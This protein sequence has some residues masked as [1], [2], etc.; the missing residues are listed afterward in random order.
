MT[1]LDDSIRRL[2]RENAELQRRLADHD[3]EVAELQRRLA[4]HKSELAEAVAQQAA[5]SELLQVI[6]SSPGDLKPVFDAML[7]KAL[8]LCDAAF[9]TLFVREDSKVRGVATR[10]LPAAL[11]EYV[12]EP[13][14]PS[15]TGFF[16]K[17]AKGQEIDHV[18]DLSAASAMTSSDP[19]ARALVEFGGAR[20]LLAVALRNN[21]TVVGAF[22]IFRTEVRPFT[23]KEI[24]LAQ[25]F[26]AQA[27]IAMENAR[28]ITETR[29]ALEQQTATAEVLQVINSSPGNLAPVFDAI[30]DKAIDVCEAAFGTLWTYDGE[31]FD[32]VALGRVPP[33]FAAYLSQKP[34]PTEPGSTHERLTRGET[35]VQVEDVAAETVIGPARR[36]LVEGGGARTIINVPLRMDDRLLG[37][38]TA[39]R[40]EVRPFT[41]KQIALL[42]NF[43]AQAVIAMENARLITETREALEQQTA[44]AEVLGVINSS[45]GNLAP[46][47]EATLDKALDLCGAAFG[48]LWIC[49]GDLFRAAALRRVPVRYAEFLARQPI[50]PAAGSSVLGQISAGNA[51]AHVLDAASDAAYQNNSEAARSLIELG[52]FRTVAGVPLR[53]DGKLLGAITIYRREVRAFTDKQIALLQNFAAQAV[54]AMENARLLGQLRQRTEE[55]AELNRGLEARVSEQVEELGRVGRLKRFLAPQLAELIVSQG[56]EKILE[57][58]R[59][60]IVVVFCDLRGY[61]AFTETAEPEEVLDFLRQYHGA[62]GPL[63]SRFEGTLDQFS[64]DG[65]MVFF[66][67]PVPV[68]DPAERAVKMAMAMRETA[69]RLITTWRQ[70]DRELGFGAG[71]AQGYATLGQIGF[72]DRSGYTA[73][74]TVCNLAARLCG[75]AKDGQILVAGRV[76]AAVRETTALEDIGPVVLKGLT[77]PVSVFN[78]LENRRT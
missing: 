61:T 11:E 47:F 27:V 24:A 63:V 59:G 48:T 18:F 5:S 37:S 28:L 51:F 69:N 68:P 73:I 56:D 60:E 8:R 67:D 54:I 19:R 58:H 42:Q 13:F 22:S 12:R 2:K 4:E 23:D 30:L 20:T 35:F 33:A 36:A 74:G 38:I 21:D 7:E 43:A 14:D 49:E 9:G 65:I 66:N 6:N 16:A 76:A 52:G 26:T 57:S 70:R 64:G 34:F 32:P 25:N 46:V 75:E 15:P 44:T 78:V 41:E 10:N 55:V 40:Q 3:S 17:A 72:A 77:Q 29:E 31:H 71:I 45:P 53:K 39:F 1:V 62:L 50:R